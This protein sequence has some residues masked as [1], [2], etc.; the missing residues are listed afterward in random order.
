MEQNS[1]KQLS[2]QVGGRLPEFVRVDHPI[3]VAFL[4]AYYEW[5]QIKDRS[6]IVL[7]PMV[8]QNVIDIDSSMD[9]FL[10]HFK[11]AYLLDFPE[12]L[13]IAKTTGLPVD[14]VKLMKN[15]KS[16]YR[17]KGTEKSYEFL[18]Q[19]LYGVSVEFYYPKK[20]V[21][22]VSDGKWYEKVAIKIS[23][24]LGNR[25][26]DSI[27]RI[28]LQ[29]NA[30]GK[31]TS[32]AKVVDV[33]VYQQGIHEIAE[34]ILSG[35]NGQFSS[36]SGG[37]QFDIDEETLQELRVYSVIGSITIN[38][39]GTG[40]AVGESVILTSASGDSG[41]GAKG[42]VSLVAAN[43]V[44]RRIRLDNFGINYGVA[45]T[46][47]I[48]SLVGSGF[49]GTATISAICQSEG[50]YLN[51][52]GRIGTNKVLQD[53][54]YYQDYSYVLKTEVVVDEY[55][56]ALRRLIH[57][58]GTAMFGQI[59]IKRCARD[60]VFNSSALIRYEVPIIGHY[61]PYTFNTFDNL[62][63]WFSVPIDG[64]NVPAGY[65]PTLHNSLIVAGVF[66][67]S[68]PVEQTLKGNP[69]SMVIPFI[70]ATGPTY[71][72]LGLTGTGFQNADPFWIVYEHPNRKI[73]GQVIAQIWRNQI[74][75]FAT[76]NEWCSITGGDPDMGGWTHDF[77]A[78]PT[79]EKKYALLQYDDTSSF[80][81]ITTR[82]FF[83]MPI[84]EE[85]DCRTESIDAYARPKIVISNPLNGQTVQSVISTSSPL[86]VSFGILNFE[87][88][89][90]F[91]GLK[92]K[93]QLDQRTPIYPLLNSSV[94][95]VVSTQPLTSPAA[96][97]IRIDMLDSENRPIIGISDTVVFFYSPP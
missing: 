40:Y 94:S 92:L 93:V 18:F 64:I 49:S 69:I 23:N 19:I 53:N 32:S 3:L 77:G 28:V 8:L 29:K 68:L 81:K 27:G 5:L 10:V 39:G 56:D 95:V 42:T 12:Q 7:S 90:R 63:D 85:F 33:T 9:E 73:R 34:L 38:N 24:S 82:S 97:R 80:R 79:L 31:I 65:N 21:L 11:R 20:D 91:D 48:Q 76:W 1:F 30:E 6:G 4:S 17:S 37:I 88:V 50:Y 26:F 51:S 25:I 35:K 87:N 67:P 86:G 66:S 83:N 41:E 55:R 57:P 46:V 84:G 58:V 52:D 22:R 43:G 14:S 89:P 72:P 71:F 44:I 2:S 59:L 78:D 60:D 16:F 70:N 47:T 54:H 62:Q 75:D 74:P 36:G 61:I 45:P 96:H 15:I 13:A